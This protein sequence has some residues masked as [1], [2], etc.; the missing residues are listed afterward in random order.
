MP[1]TISGQLM[2]W[3]K[4]T[5]DFVADRA[6]SELPETFRDHRLDVTFTNTATGETFRAPGFFAADGDAAD[7]G[8]TSG[9][10]WR[11][12]F[13]PPSEGAWSYQASFRT[14]SDIAASLD[15][16]GRRADRI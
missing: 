7:S 3:H 10:V 13:N 5:L 15:R 8:A 6:F 14:G 4:V 11:V 2:T 9:D 1:A 12:N 16:I